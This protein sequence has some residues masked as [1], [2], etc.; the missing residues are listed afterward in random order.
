M[1]S[2]TSSF[3]AQE[4]TR[5]DLVSIAALLVALLAAVYTRRQS[6]EATKS[7]LA[8]QRESRRPQRL[9]VLR[10]MREFCS[11]CGKYYTLYL[12][13]RTNG[14]RDLVA[15]TLAFH[16][17]IENAAISDMPAVA[18]EAKLLESRAWSLQRLLDRLGAPTIDM[19][20]DVRLKPTLNEIENLM[21]LIAAQSSQLSNIFAPYLRQDFDAIHS[22]ER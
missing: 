6:V 21:D 9:E 20:E 18:A 3:L 22:N 15:S 1:S 8:S 16:E 2:F 4:F 11:Y 17:A 13:G 12:H 19:A 10:E 7:R 5:A 14:T